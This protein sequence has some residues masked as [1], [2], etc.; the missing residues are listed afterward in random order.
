MMD[1]LAKLL[2]LFE[3]QLNILDA[4]NSEKKNTKDGLK[5]TYLYKI[6]D[7]FINYISDVI[8]SE[9]YNDRVKLFFETVFNRNH[10][11]GSAVY[12]VEKN[13]PKGANELSK[14]RKA[15]SVDEYFIALNRF[16][17]LVLVKEYHNPTI[18]KLLSYS[19]ELKAEVIEKVEADGFELLEKESYPAIQKNE[20]EYILNFMENK[21]RISDLDRKVIILFK[22]LL[23][24]GITVR[25]VSKIKVNHIDLKKRTLKIECKRHDYLQNVYLELPYGLY[26]DIEEYI[27]IKGLDAEDY[28][29]DIE[30]NESLPSSVFSFLL[31]KIKKAY[32]MEVNNNSLILKRFTAYGM[33]KYAISNMLDASINIP[34][35]E[36]LTDRTVDFILSCRPEKIKNSADYNHYI[37][38][39]MRSTSTYKEMQ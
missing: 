17:E 11:I 2:E 8:S 1:E 30:E 32:S 20:Y 23:L 16:H 31:Y 33:A 25:K 13:K 9:G 18:F 7:Y 4:L 28:L 21:S 36:M 27:K 24:Y 26:I 22:L 5:G 39:K 14:E 10:I 35:I 3:V 15:S 29:F 37:N 12:Y 6:R 38:Y 34:V 19:D